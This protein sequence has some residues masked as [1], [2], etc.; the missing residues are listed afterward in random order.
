VSLKKIVAAV[1]P[2]LT[3]DEQDEFVR[4]LP[5]N[6]DVLDQTMRGAYND[7]DALNPEEKTQLVGGHSEIDRNMATAKNFRAAQNEADNQ[8]SGNFGLDFENPERALLVDPGPSNVLEYGVN[9][10]QRGALKTLPLVKKV[11]GFLERT[12]GGLTGNQD[13]EKSGQ[14]LD[15]AAAIDQ[16]A[17]DIALPPGTPSVSDTGIGVDSLPMNVL[18]GT[19][20]A[21]EMA[22]DLAMM[23]A[24]TGG[25]KALGAAEKLA[26]VAGPALVMAPGSV[27]KTSDLIEQKTGQFSP[28]TS[29]VAGSAEALLWSGALQRI[30][31]GGASQ[32]AA[33]N[34]LTGMAQRGNWGRIAQIAGMTVEGAAR[35]AAKMGATGTAADLMTQAAVKSVDPTQEIDPVKALVEGGAPAAFQGLALGAHGGMSEG[36]AARDRLAGVPAMPA[37]AAKSFVA[38]LPEFVGNDLAPVAEPVADPAP[39]APAEPAKPGPMSGIDFTPPAPSVLPVQPAGVMTEAL[40]GQV[41]IE[42]KAVTAKGMAVP[43]RFRVVDADQVLTSNQEGYP[44]DILQGRDRTRAASVDQINSIAQGPRAEELIT[45]FVKASDGAPVIGP[46]GLVESGNGRTIGLRM[47]YDAGNGEGY[48]Q[49]LLDNAQKFGLDPAAIQGMKKPMLV[50]ERTAELSP[51]DR[52]AFADQANQRSQLAMSATEQAMKDAGAV[53]EIL[54]A[55]NVSEDGNLNTA[56]NAGFFREFFRRTSSAEE[57]GQNMTPTGEISQ[58]GL[59][60]VK[61]ALFAWAYGD[62]KAVGTLAEDPDANVKNVLNGL[63]RAAPDT[64]KVNRDIADGALFDAGIS[65]E[66]SEAANKLSELRRQKETVDGYL[67]QGQLIPDGM[68]EAGKTFLRFLDQN[69][70][71]PNKIA[72]LVKEYNDL[73][74]GAGDPRQPTLF[75]P[76]EAPDKA[77]LLKHAIEK[78]D[79]DP[80]DRFA[81]AAQ[82]GA[83]AAFQDG[84]V[85]PQNSAEPAGSTGSARSAEPSDGIQNFD[86]STGRIDRRDM[87]QDTVDPTIKAP[88]KRSKIMELFQ[89]LLPIRQGKM[90]A[91][92]NVLGTYNTKE[93]LIRLRDGKDIEVGSHELG[94]HLSVLM[95]WNDATLAPFSGELLPISSPGKGGKPTLQ[96]GLAEFARYYLTDPIKAAQKAPGFLVEFQKRLAANK[97]MNTAMNTIR[98]EIE[99]YFRQDPVMRVISNIDVPGAPTLLEKYRKLSGNF[100]DLYKTVVD[101]LEPL[102]KVEMEMNGGKLLPA[103]LSPYKIARLFSGAMGK[104][105]AFIDHKPF[106]YDTLKFSGKGLREILEPAGNRL[107]DL[108]AY[109]VARRAKEKYFQQGPRG[110]DVDTGIKIEDALETMKRFDDQVIGK[111]RNGNDRKFSD[112]AQDLYKYQDQ[113]MQYLVDGGILSSADRALIRSKNQDYIPFYRIMGE[114]GEGD[115]TIGGGSGSGSGF[116]VK[117]S[118]VKKMKGS[119]RDII[120]PLESVIK[121]TYAFIQA[122]ERNAV[123]QALVNLARKSGGMG[124]YVAEIPDQQ[125]AIQFSLDEIRRQMTP[126]ELSH[127]NALPQSLQ[128]KMFMV[129]RKGNTPQKGVI[130]VFDGGQQKLYQVHPEIENVLKSLDRETAPLWIQLMAKPAAWLRAG[131]TLTP[132]FTAR[133]IVMDTLSSALFSRYQAVPVVDV[134]RAVFHGISNT[135]RRSETYW[136]WMASGGAGAELVALNREGLQGELQR[137]LENPKGLA[138]FTNLITSPIKTLELMSKFSEQVTRVGEFTLGLQKEKP[139]KAGAMEAG[140]ASRDVSLDFARMGAVTQNLN[141]MIAFQNAAVQGIDKFIN[142]S[143]DSFRRDPVQMT[144]RAMAYLVM[145]TLYA[146]MA[147]KDDPRYQDV[148]QIVKDTH[149]IHISGPSITRAEWDKLTLDQ[150]AALVKNSV[151]RI[152]KP[153]ELGLL[154]SSLVERCVNKYYLKD[155][156]A[157]DD[158]GDSLKAAFMPNVIPTSAAPI[159]EHILN[160]SMWTGQDLIPDNQMK[161]EPEL[162][163]G[164]KTSGTAKAIGK[165]I[166]VAPTVLDNYGRG[167]GG[168]MFAHGIG[169][170]DAAGEALGILPKTNKPEAQNQDIPGVK[171]FAYPAFQRSE[172]VKRFRNQF[173]DASRK[174][175]TM[176]YYFEH[177]QADEAKQ[178]QASGV[179]AKLTEV[180]KA[181]GQISERIQQLTDDKKMDPKQKANEIQKMYILR[182]ETARQGSLIYDKLDQLH[183]ES[184]KK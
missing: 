80:R 143:V 158:F 45:D 31:G 33:Q 4:L 68:S 110:K 3:P 184:K 157:F 55:L 24:A 173:N 137:V 28:A 27:T 145:P 115:L 147:N 182:S 92:Q 48:R 146:W 116:E 26:E 18:Q 156:H 141:R 86:Q 113:V 17:I 62:P 19:D 14:A 151:Y 162:Q 142:G 16:Q 171:G 60:R 67:A 161:L 32:E 130:S 180:N 41:G 125:K 177:G 150:K 82:D 81:P 44:V 20:A 22:P 94:H 122:A 72:N 178:K 175:E 69:K 15:Q 25:M 36:M 52:M 135:G 114:P 37:D 34:I 124:K 123:G 51:A 57:M 91:P 108:R 103:Y 152:P 12:Y 83:I 50:R 43:V 107:M 49:Y 120:D 39:V 112:V 99:N 148:E 63:L 61:N 98:G 101:R 85:S 102:R 75:G 140:L 154:F 121:N 64:A 133:N 42:S 165:K 9:A 163:F 73:L 71:F 131:A 134:L 21:V 66:I 8:P 132:E 126:A 181:L 38:N 54:G 119:T 70:R 166:G 167:F 76:A 168:G 117:N 155:K 29:L 84:P 160:K 174:Y 109:L 104:A 7:W 5:E 176:K 93:Q 97:E 172:M 58:T 179:Y 65:G 2:D 136:K 1:H 77:L 78:V 35:E 105:A 6:P 159:A 169:A 149:W 129:F 100:G 88:V 128:D 74:R 40:P 13:W 53:P 144:A 139:G 96:E 127:F 138:R 56:G 95:G 11:G 118:P 47:A 111:D 164:P 23:G 59:A 153:R 183:E 90:K 89:A 87:T 30:M 106:D 46:D 79:A 170:V 10:I